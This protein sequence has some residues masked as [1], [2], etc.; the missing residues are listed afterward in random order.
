VLT[1][2]GTTQ[3]LTLDGKV[4]G[5]ITDSLSA[6]NM[7]FDEL[8]SGETGGWPAGN[9]GFDPFVG[10]IKT[11]QIISGTLLPGSMTFSTS[12]GNQ[13]TFT[14]PDAGTYT[15]SLVATDKDGGTGMHTASLTATEIPI[16]VSAG[17][18]AMVQQATAFTR[19]GSVSDAPGDG[20]WTA[21]V[22]YGDGTG[23]Q[24]LSLTGQ[25]FTLNHTF[26]NAG[27]FTVSVSVTNQ[28]KLTGTASFNATVSGFTVNDGSPQESMVRSLIYVFPHRTQVE[29]GAFVLLRDGQPSKIDLNIAPQPD[30]MTYIVTFGGPG[31][32]GGSVPDGDYTLITLANK[33]KVLSGPPLTSNDVNTFDRLFG[34]AD[35]DGVVNATDKA[36]LKEAKADASSPYV[37]DFEYEGKPGIDK[38]DIAQFNKRYR[39]KL[40][41]PKKAPAKFNGRTVLHQGAVQP[42]TSQRTRP[43]LSDVT[44][45]D[46]SPGHR[47]L[48]MTTRATR[49]AVIERR[50]V[51]PPS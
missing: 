38:T 36:L 4:I 32:I 1:A 5:T 15:L 50:I 3:T 35:G 42:K 21:T 20:P 6:L 28:D 10:A 44:T 8:G 49:I 26:A 18:S 14:P 27:T 22:N 19:T 48:P 34:D 16:T 25:S 30:G 2:S 45:V 31:V 39:A 46:R 12:G 29:P 37:A 41:P 7:T 17:S 13:V 33:V 11:V 43:G 23:S 47:R 24:P 51:K 9:G 40:D